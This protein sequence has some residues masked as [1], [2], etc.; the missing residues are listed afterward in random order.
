MTYYAV[1]TAAA[2]VAAICPGVHILHIRQ[3]DHN[4]RYIECVSCRQNLTRGNDD[5][6]FVH[7]AVDCPYSDHGALPPISPPSPL[8]E[9]QSKQASCIQGACGRRMVRADGRWHRA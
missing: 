8:G 1:P 4:N 7:A 6:H 2:Q 5:W 9:H 3:T